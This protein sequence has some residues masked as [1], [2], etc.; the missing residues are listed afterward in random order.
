MKCSETNP[1][2]G[3]SR[4]AALEAVYRLYDRFVE[5]LNLFCRRGCAHCCTANVTLT[6]LEARYLLDALRRSVRADLLQRLAAQT[7]SH[8]PAPPLTTNQLARLCAEGR[9]PPEAPEAADAGHCPLLTRKTCPVYAARPFACRCLVSTSDCGVSGY[10]SMD[11]FT[12]SLNTVFLQCIE[13][14]DAGGV[15]GSLAVLPIWL[16]RFPGWVPPP[17]TDLPSGL[18]AN[19]PLTVLMVPPEHRAAMAPWLERLRQ[20]MTP[21]HPAGR[22]KTEKQTTAEEGPHGKKTAC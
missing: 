16:G 11:E 4:L 19:S 17:D 15:S 18:A 21:G 9:T 7:D 22:D 2:H 1:V 6:S 3:E 10:A 8:P 5:G 13:H 14:L 12:L 20:A